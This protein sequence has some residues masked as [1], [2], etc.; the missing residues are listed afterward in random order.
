MNTIVKKIFIA[1]FV[2]TLFTVPFGSAAF[3]ADEEKKLESYEDVNP[4]TV[5]MDV[6]IVRPISLVMIP[7]TSVLCVLALP[8]TLAQ[9]NTGEVFDMMVVDTCR[10]TFTRPLGHDTPFN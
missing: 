7:V 10:Y 6:V 8:Y 2:V 4:F 1:I 3:A 9:G 5:T